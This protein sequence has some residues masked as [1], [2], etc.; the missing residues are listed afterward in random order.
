[1]SWRIIPNAEILRPE[2]LSRAVLVAALGEGSVP[3]HSREA[4]DA[5]I[6]EVMRIALWK[7]SDGGRESI[8][9]T[10]LRHWVVRKLRP[11][12]PGLWENREV[13]ADALDRL[14]FHGD[15]LDLRA[16]RT[17]PAPTRLLE[18]G[19]GSYAILSGRP[20]DELAF[21]KD[22]IV[23]AQHARLLRIT[24]DEVRSIGIPL[25]DREGYLLPFGPLPTAPEV[26]LGGILERAPTQPPRGEAWQ[27]YARTARNLTGFLWLDHADRSRRSPL[28]VKFHGA[29]FT[30]W[31]EPLGGT[32]LTYLIRED[33]TT[34]LAYPVEQ[35]ETRQV[36]LAL[37]HIA[38]MGREGAVR[39]VGD[40]A[41][42]E[43]D[44]GPDF[45]LSRWLAVIGARAHLKRGE[46]RTWTITASAVDRTSEIL[47][48]LGV[49]IKVHGANQR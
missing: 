15:V 35:T 43:L 45:Y 37:D 4:E 16:G 41:T 27:Y 6:A 42:L 8:H 31:R 30:L 2:E 9:K 18:I 38:G 17:L 23:R 40:S 26:L 36:C 19:E 24:R 12:V 34:P 28:R 10:S 13:F 49:S 47:Y 44:F 22:K 25:Q 11:V 5:L 1:M 48:A 21:A 33:A 7:M 32:N 39:V 14:V 20:S 46:H 3:A 29:E